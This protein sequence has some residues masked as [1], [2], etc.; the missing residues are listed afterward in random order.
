[1]PARPPLYYHRA[2]LT[3]VTQLAVLAFTM[4]TALITFSIAL[5]AVALLLGETVIV[6]FVP[7]LAP[8]RASID[9]ELA[10]EGRDAAALAHA[11]LLANMRDAHA[12]ELMYLERLATDV[13]AAWTYEPSDVAVDR[14]L[15]L[16]GL[17]GS[18]VRLAIAYH[19]NT[20]AFT[21]EGWAALEAE[22]ARLAELP[23]A[24]SDEWIARRRAVLDMRRAAWMRAGADRELL[25]HAL[26]TIGEVMRFVH[27]LAATTHHDPGRAD[28]DRVLAECT[29]ALD[30]VRR[31]EAD[32]P[33]D[34]AIEAVTHAYA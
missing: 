25:V 33:V 4:A 8:F 31:L 29:G 3:H 6:A 17:L 26:G 14:V 18:Y 27:D 16:D 13:H 24:D 19:R 12:T 23:R 22:A 10:R 2:A 15:G 5:A 1:M 20:V 7:R 30:R 28:L 11:A 21:A 34:C 32:V 9:R